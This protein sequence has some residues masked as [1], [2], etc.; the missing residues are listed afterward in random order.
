[1]KMCL[2]DMWLW[3]PTWHCMHM[4]KILLYMYQYQRGLSM[5][6][7]NFTA[8]A[9][10]SPLISYHAE[11][12]YFYKC[13]QTFLTIVSYNISVHYNYNFNRKGCIASIIVHMCYHEYH[14]LAG[15]WRCARGWPLLWEKVMAVTFTRLDLC[16]F[17]P[18]INTDLPKFTRQLAL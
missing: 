11:W 17:T 9:S 2:S 5:N 6:I 1:M 7:I 4:H 8:A 10:I 14:F 3:L 13:F 12:Y 18:F 16:I 15:S